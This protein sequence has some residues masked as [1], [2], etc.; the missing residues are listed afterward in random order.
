MADTKS[1]RYRSGTPA[2]K[3][4]APHAAPHIA[5]TA[6][7]FGT[8]EQ[9]RRDA[10]L[11]ASGVARSIVAARTELI[12]PQHPQPSPERRI[13]HRPLPRFRFARRNAV[14]Y[15]PAELV[16]RLELPIRIEDRRA[17]D[18]LS[19]PPS[20]S[21]CRLPSLTSVA[22]ATRFVLSLRDSTSVFTLGTGWS[23]G[24]S[25]RRARTRSRAK[26]DIPQR[27][28][29]RRQSTRS[30]SDSCFLAFVDR[31]WSSLG[32]DTRNPHGQRQISRCVV[33]FGRYT[34]VRPPGLRNQQRKP[35]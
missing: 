29:N 35:A 1:T 32:K 21:S 31:R 12:E 11:D 6:S 27:L 23:G 17:G 33:N 24:R 13:G 19:V 9:F 8:F 22:A 16:T 2:A 14:T 25:V 7:H 20:S 28:A 30:G 10:M 3:T 15:I 4:Y 5:G 18:G 26:A 34:G